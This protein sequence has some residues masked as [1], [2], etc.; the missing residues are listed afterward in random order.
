MKRNKKLLI[1]L[2]VLVLAAA[3]LIIIKTVSSKSDDEDTTTDISVSSLTADD[4]TAVEW[5]NDSGSIK[6]SR[7]SSGSWS[8]PADS[9]FPLSQSEAKE[10]LTAAASVSSDLLVTDAPE[11]LADYGLKTP[12]V[13]VDITMKDGSTVSYSI[14][15]ENTLHSEYYFKLS[16]SDSVYLVSSDMEKTFTQGLLDI[17]QMEELPDIDTVNSVAIEPSGHS[18]MQIRYYADGLSTCYTPEYKHFLISGSS[19]IPV[20]ETT[21][22]GLFNEISGLSWTSCAAY[23][24]TDDQLAAWALDD[25][26]ATKVFAEYTYNEKTDSGETETDGSTVYT[27]EKTAGSL[28]LLVG[29]SD[30]S[31]VYVRLKD[32]RMVYLVAQSSVTDMLYTDPMNFMPDALCYVDTSTVNRLEITYGGQS[33]TISKTGTTENV[34][35]ADGEDTT[36]TSYT[37][38]SCGNDYSESEYVNFITKFFELAPTYKKD[39]DITPEGDPVLTASVDTDN[40]SFTFS[41][42]SYNDDSLLLSIDGVSRLIFAQSDITDLN[43]PG[44]ETADQSTT[45]S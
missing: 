19:Y 16:S 32:S 42:Y 40:G 28:T 33:Y 10:I 38:S 18:V 5:A 35:D 34:T 21:G 2:L 29:A 24:A 31:N 12:A 36:E 14:G 4:V 13:T 20:D 17:V 11:D 26:S 6:I 1:L 44:L 25:A 41:M 8:Y 22:K 3:A 43:I 37:Y 7:D 27:T 45:A 30:S 39:S 23:N 9:A 15:S